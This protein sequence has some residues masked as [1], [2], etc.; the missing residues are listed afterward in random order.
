MA[1]K[2]DEKVVNLKEVNIQ[3][4]MRYIFIHNKKVKLKRMTTAGMV[5]ARILIHSNHFGKICGSF[6]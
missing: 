2:V 1:D 5:A 4:T 3:T 6:L